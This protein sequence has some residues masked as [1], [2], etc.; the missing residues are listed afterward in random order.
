MKTSCE[1]FARTSINED[2]FCP[3]N[4]IANPCDRCMIHVDVVDINNNK[5]I[6]CALSFAALSAPCEV[7]N[8]AS[9]QTIPIIKR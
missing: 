7:F 6:V 8:K 2:R 5:A 1:E 4:G 9:I 3:F